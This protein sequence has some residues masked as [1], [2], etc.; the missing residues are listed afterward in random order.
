MSSYSASRLSY[1][2]AINSSLSG[3]I[4]DLVS[5]NTSL[6][7]SSPSGPGRERWH[8]KGPLP[9]P[10]LYFWPSAAAAQSEDDSFRFARSSS[11][12]GLFYFYSELKNTHTRQTIAYRATRRSTSGACAAST[13]NAAR[14][15]SASSRAH[16]SASS[17][18]LS[19]HIPSR[20]ICHLRAHRA[21]H[22]SG[23]T[24]TTVRIMSPRSSAPHPPSPIR[25]TQGAQ[26]SLRR[27]WVRMDVGSTSWWCNK[28][29]VE[30][31]WENGVGAAFTRA[32][33]GG[34]SCQT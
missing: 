13:K 4:A 15:R 9:P 21:P 20:Y 6:A 30:R 28:K 11:I 2:N 34:D 31:E 29:P 14:V 33:C 19:N 23:S 16:R 1:Q 17:W 10:F 12:E 5:E 25:A 32:I 18:C 27:A 24:S 3:N 26:A 22:S 8:P 7:S